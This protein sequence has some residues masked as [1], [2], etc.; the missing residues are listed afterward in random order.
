MVRAKK[1]AVATAMATRSGERPSARIA[2]MARITTMKWWIQD[3]GESSTHSSAVTAIASAARDSRASRLTTA[4]P[5]TAAITATAAHSAPGAW[6]GR[7]SLSRMPRSDWFEVPA[8]DPSRPDWK[9]AF[10]Q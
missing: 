9:I 3:T 10:V 4:N 7:N 2:P 6:P 5:A 1:A 8:L